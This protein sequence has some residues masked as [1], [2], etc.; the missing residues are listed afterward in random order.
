LR[1][2]YSY[3][4]IIRVI[5]LYY[6]RD[7]SS[8][9]SKHINVKFLVINDKVRNLILSVDCDS[10]ILNIIDPLIKRIPPKVFFEHIAHMGMTSHDDIMV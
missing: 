9:K 10:T 8:V 2:H 1:G 4:V 3:T 6:N 7:K 5:E